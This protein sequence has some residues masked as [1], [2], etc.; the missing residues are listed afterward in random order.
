MEGKM[1]RAELVMVREMKKWK[2]C[3]LKKGES[4]HMTT[5]MRVNFVRPDD[6]DE[7]HTIQDELPKEYDVFGDFS[8]NTKI[9]YEDARRVKR[10]WAEEKIPDVKWRGRWNTSWDFGKMPR[11]PPVLSDRARVDPWE[12]SRERTGR[13]WK[14][15][16]SR[17]TS[18][19]NN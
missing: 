19:G 2:S 5:T 6:K 18:D 15:T 12:C 4:R 3:K 17:V 8:L 14:K 16:V 10:K 13:D 11:C 7:L 9:V 1:V